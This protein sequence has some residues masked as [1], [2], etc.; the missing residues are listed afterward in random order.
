[1]QHI[2]RVQGFEGSQSLINEVLTV[3]V[4]ELLRAYDAV[5]I[6]FHELLHEVDLLEVGKAGW[7][8]DVQDRDD[9]LVM[10]MP[11]ELDLA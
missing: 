1:M 2:G 8:Q 3:I 11:Q 5:E 6:R 9:I 4:A 7:A 10:K